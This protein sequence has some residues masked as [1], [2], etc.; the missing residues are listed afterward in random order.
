MNLDVGTEYIM[1]ESLKV[2]CCDYTLK[3]KEVIS[4]WNQTSKNRVIIRTRTGSL[5]K[6]KCSALNRTAK[7]KKC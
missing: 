6:I 2:L 5:H 7:E 1:E 4:V 3:P